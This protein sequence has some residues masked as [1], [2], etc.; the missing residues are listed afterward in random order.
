METDCILCTGEFATP[1]HC[2]GL[3]GIGTRAGALLLCDERIA[4]L[5]GPDVNL[6]QR[7]LAYGVGNGFGVFSP[8]VGNSWPVTER[9]IVT[10]PSALAFARN[11]LTAIEVKQQDSSTFCL[12]EMTCCT[13]VVADRN[14]TAVYA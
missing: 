12:N 10:S 14:Q 5:N 13:F 7:Q 6:A 9:G 3:H 4:L 2:W 11:H 1:Y 8:I